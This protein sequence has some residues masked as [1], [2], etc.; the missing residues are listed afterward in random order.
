[1]KKFVFALIAF[2]FVTVAFASPPEIENT[3]KFA[4]EQLE[5]IDLSI[6][7]QNDFNAII[8]NKSQREVKTKANIDVQNSSFI[9]VKTASIN[10]F[11]ICYTQLYKTS[12]YNYL[13]DYRKLCQINKH[14]RSLLS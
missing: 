8:F 14:Q 13:I 1:M 7:N 3:K 4:I 12:K 5:M 6:V 2:L 9:E 11:G 10:P